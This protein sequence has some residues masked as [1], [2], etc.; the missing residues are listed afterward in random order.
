V[1]KGCFF[2]PTVKR[3]F[4]NQS[5][6]KATANTQS[7]ASQ[8]Q[9]LKSLEVILQSAQINDTTR[10][11]NLIGINSPKNN[12]NIQQLNLRPGLL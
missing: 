3:G 1:K 4:D 5:P 9:A 6:V 8:Y 2:K 7:I 12:K 10:L 11:V